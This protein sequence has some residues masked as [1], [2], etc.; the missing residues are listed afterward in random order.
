MK[1][2]S[3][4]SLLRNNS[5]WHWWLFLIL[6]QPFCTGWQQHQENGIYRA[7]MQGKAQWYVCWYQQSPTACCIQGCCSYY[8]IICS[9]QYPHAQEFT[10][11]KNTLWH[12]RDYGT[13]LVLNVC[14][15]SLVQVDLDQ[16]RAVELDS[17]SLANDFWW[18]TQVLQHGIVYRCQRAAVITS[19]DLQRYWQQ[20]SEIKQINSCSATSH[21]IIILETCCVQK[22]F[23]SLQE[24]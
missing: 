10:C 15:L 1:Q 16:P 13:N 20:S 3:Q 7:L 19:Q 9:I 5:E 21:K 23:N 17:N 22:H 12:W 18:E 6:H 8:Y 14:L 4:I 2:K 24:K 11:T